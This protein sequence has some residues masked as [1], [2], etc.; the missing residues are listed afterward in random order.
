[1]DFFNSITIKIEIN[2]LI[3]TVQMI[4]ETVRK[5]KFHIQHA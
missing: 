2:V 3:F 1:M 4:L 5:L